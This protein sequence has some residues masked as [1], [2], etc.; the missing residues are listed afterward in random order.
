MLFISDLNF[1]LQ[2]HVKTTFLSNLEKLPKQICLTCSR[3][4]TEAVSFVK[5]CI[6]THRTCLGSAVFQNQRVTRKSLRTR[7]LN[8][9]VDKSL[10]Q[11]KT[12]EIEF[13]NEEEETI[14][15]DFPYEDDS[16]ESSEQPKNSLEP[17]E[18]VPVTEPTEQTYPCSECDRKFDSLNFLQQ[19]SLIHL[20]PPTFICNFCDRSFVNKFR[21][22][23]HLRTHSDERPYKCTDC[24]KAFR[25]ANALR[26]H[27]RRHTGQKPYQCQICEKCFRQ[28]TTLITHMTLH[29]GKNV[30]C[31]KCDKT[32]S[33]S[34]YLIA[35][36]REHNGIRPY[37]CHICPSRRYK[38]KSHL[39]QHLSVH[40][41]IR[42]PCE[43]CGKEYSKKWSLKVHMYSHEPEDKLPYRC[44]V[45]G[46]TFVI[47]NKLHS[48]IKLK[49]SSVVSEA[50]D[51]KIVDDAP[52]PSNVVEVE[53]RE[54]VVE[55]PIQIR[56]I[57]ILTPRSSQIC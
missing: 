10:I 30:K 41:G 4:L 11:P 50:M 24:D 1:L 12:P 44:E 53:T 37:A 48:H 16:H 14:I 25:Q 27:R 45:C 19:H 46:L 47:R 6:E 31:K 32:F 57:I 22:K 42:F 28:K 21:L 9:K 15:E 3:K 18:T 35:H 7:T 33:R 56:E 51:I 17:K 38:Q 26:C 29:T 8:V 23:S 49:H 55:Q 20:P 2:S 39:D 5:Q 54:M 43:I 34:S 13:K 52:A 40:S 36:M